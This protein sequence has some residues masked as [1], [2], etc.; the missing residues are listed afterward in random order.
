MAR[1]LDM[2]DLERMIVYLELKLSKNVDKFEFEGA[3]K[4][5]TVMFDTVKLIEKIRRADMN[6]LN[7]WF[8]IHDNSVHV[9]K[10]DFYAGQIAVRQ[11][12]AGGEFICRPLREG[13]WREGEK[14]KARNA[15][16]GYRNGGRIGHW[17]DYSYTDIITG[18]KHRVE[19]KHCEGW[20]EPNTSGR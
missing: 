9:R 4:N 2:E 14:E 6:Q 3:T 17:Y 13:D 20:F 5:C 10:M 8:R 1:R 15:N 7:K 11:F 18:E 19:V 12:M 16:N